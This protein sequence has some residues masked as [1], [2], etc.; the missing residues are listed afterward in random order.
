MPKPGFSWLRANLK[1]YSVTKLSFRS[2]ALFLE[3]SGETFSFQKKY[4]SLKK[5]S[6]NRAA[7]SLVRKTFLVFF[8]RSL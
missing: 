4:L 6:V 7:A 3:S 8:F 1:G 2:G 5:L